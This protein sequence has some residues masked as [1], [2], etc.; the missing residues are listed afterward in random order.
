MRERHIFLIFFLRDSSQGGRVPTRTPARPPGIIAAKR[1]YVNHIT[2]KKKKPPY[3]RRAPPAGREYRS[4]V[5]ITSTAAVMNRPRRRSTGRPGSRVN[6]KNSRCCG[7]GVVVLLNSLDDVYFAAS[8]HNAFTT[9][10]HYSCWDCCHGTTA[11]DTYT[12]TH[13]NRCRPYTG[14]E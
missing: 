14:K 13:A 12:H 10:V 6:I 3:T 2:R 5:I 1:T 11:R 7:G 9:T 8:L 4:R